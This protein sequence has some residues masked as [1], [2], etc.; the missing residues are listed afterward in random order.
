MSQPGFLDQSLFAELAEKAAA[1]PRGR[2][3]HNFHQMEEPCHRMAVGLQ[4]GTYIPPH[5]H[6]NA[7]KAETLI[8]LRGTL[9]LLI[10]TETGEVVAKRVLKAGG[11]CL[12]VDLPPGTFHGLVVLEADSMMFECKAGP[13]RPVGEGEMASWAPREGE[14]GVAEYQAWMR[15]HF[16]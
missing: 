4:P 8:V 15:A 7:D 3:H 14:P 2:Q 6:L 12:G 9:G 1:S 11:D 10:F 5:R 13:Y 16:D